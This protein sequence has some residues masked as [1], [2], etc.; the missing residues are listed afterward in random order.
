ML[1]SVGCE[2][3]YTLPAPTP[4][5]ALVQP[6]SDPAHRVVWE[7]RR[8]A[9]ETPH[10]E[11]RDLFGNR[12]ER[13]TLPAGESSIAYDA[14]V[15]VSG[16][17]DEVSLNA[18]A[19]SVADLPDDLLVYTLS[20]R[21]CPT[22]TMAQTAWRLFG[23]VPPGWGQVQAICD[24]IHTNIE[25]GLLHSTPN[26]TA[27]DVYVASGGMCRDFAH[28]AI[29]F[30]RALSIPARY[31]FGYMPDIGV[32]GP[33]PPMDFHAWFEAWLE[34]RWWTFDARFNTPRIGR[35]PIGVGRDAVDVAMMTTYGPAEFQHMVV[36]TDRVDSATPPQRTEPTLQ[37]LLR[38]QSEG[39]LVGV[40]R[41]R[42]GQVR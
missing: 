33:F 37:G 20:S 3:T 24:W 40:E 10:H 16:A 42:S 30:C 14:V 32:P 8:F 41:G 31:V 12:C 9:P 27:L 36:W 1:L 25:Y 21:Y 11:Y 28:L 5:V 38:Q 19:T 18:Q 34:G 4:A 29:T 13:L 39:L 6:R 15:D 2:F 35:I 17:P 23:H 26:T 7:E 22:E